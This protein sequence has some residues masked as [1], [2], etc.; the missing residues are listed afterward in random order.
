MQKQSGVVDL[1]ISH[2]DATRVGLLRQLTSLV[3]SEPGG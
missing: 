2:V 1:D 3:E